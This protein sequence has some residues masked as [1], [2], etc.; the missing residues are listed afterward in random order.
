MSP[1]TEQLIRDYLNRLSV[2]AR[3]QLGP[4]DR[5]ALVDRTR[6]FIERKTGFAGR[7]TTLE[8]GRLLSG[9]GD[10]AGLVSQE[11]QRLA[12]LRGEAMEPV[13]RG[14]LAR[15]LRGEPGKMRGG[16]WHWPVQPGSR[17]DL[18]FTLIDGGAPGGGRA[19]FGR[20]AA[21]PE[22]A[23]S[24]AAE[25]ARQSVPSPAPPGD[26]GPHHAGAAS[27]LWPA[28]AAG[29]ADDG[30]IGRDTAERD[31][32]EHGAGRGGTGQQ[33]ADRQAPDQQS[34]E[35]P[36]L[37]QP[38]PDRQAPGLQA[39]GPNTATTAPGA[40]L[41][42]LAAMTWRL[43]TDEPEPRRPSRTWQ[44]LASA[45]GW[46]RRHKLEAVAIALLGLGGVIFPPVWLVGAAVALAS[47]LWDYRD[48]WLALALPVVLTVIGTAVGVAVGSRASFG[49]GMHE[50]WV[51]AVAFCRATAVLSACYLGWRAARGRRPP[52]APPW[53]K[54]HR[55][56]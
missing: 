3:G 39:P 47:R 2:A 8:V 22:A 19:A 29:A 5:R 46:S 54:P 18:Q 7:P 35:Q 51:F 21:D 28:L 42:G 11:R 33:G 50:A 27:R 24:V 20:A 13:S 37:D 53:D 15:V 36:A 14:L 38:A 23:S 31:S 1:P 10:P 43:A 34:L 45:G 6:E 44:L 12:M 40:R 32:D 30:T 25:A 9:L 26:P 16:S 56:S 55:V 49:H 17:A 41:T 48:K 4:D 52:A